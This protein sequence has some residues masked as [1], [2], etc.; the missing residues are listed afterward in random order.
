MSYGPR[1]GPRSHGRPCPSGDPRCGCQRSLPMMPFARQARLCTADVGEAVTEAGRV[2]SAHRVW[3]RG[4]EFHAR[5]HATAVG[6]LTLICIYYEQAVVLDAVRPLDYYTLQTVLRGGYEISS[7][8]D[9]TQVNRGA[10][11]VLPPTDHLRIRFAPETVQIGVKIP[12][13][14]LERV[15]SRLGLPP[16]T[17]GTP[18]DLAVVGR[19]AWVETLRVVVDAVN[20]SPGHELD[21]KVGEEL[22]RMLLT[23]LVLSQPVRGEPLRPRSTGFRGRQAAAAAAERMR[24]APEE[25]IDIPGLA[26]ETGVSLR[27]LQEG[28]KDL[29]GRSPTAYL[30]QIRLELAHERLRDPAA[31]ATVTDVAL[32]CGFSH[33]GRFAGAY[34]EHFGLPPSHTLARSR[35]TDSTSQAG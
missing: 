30:R 19:P 35:K 7:D 5:L 2:M 6:K 26:R 8:A 12:T 16:E 29:H 1:R 34:R 14:A 9:T 3:L 11:C 4:N 28:F 24:A 13:I 23:A 21:P 17:G 15:L 10:S 25:P 27:T 33:L 22:E 31:T 32:A 20:A 18:F